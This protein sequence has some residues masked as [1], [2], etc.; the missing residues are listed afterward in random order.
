VRILIVEDDTNLAASLAEA[1][2]GEGFLVDAVHDG[3]AALSFAA[4]HEISLIVLDRDLP[5]MTGDGVCRALR[6]IAPPHP[7]AASGTTRSALIGGWS[8][9]RCTRCARSSVHRP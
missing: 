9:W 3:A 7:P 1:L 4:T 6:A 5:V 2:R 8:K